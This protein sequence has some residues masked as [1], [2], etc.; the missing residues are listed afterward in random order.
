MVLLKS[1]RC[2][3]VENVIL[4][5]ILLTVSCYSRNVVIVATRDKTFYRRSKEILHFLPVRNKFLPLQKDMH[6]KS[7]FVHLDE[8]FPRC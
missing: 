4:W 1:N 7:H 3:L 5:L 6:A 2:F 8:V